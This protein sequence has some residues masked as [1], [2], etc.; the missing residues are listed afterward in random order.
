MSDRFASKLPSQRQLRVGEELRD[1]ISMALRR[2]DFRDPVLMDVNL[3]VTEVSVSPDLKNCTAYVIPLGGGFDA[4]MIKALNKA[5]SYLRSSVAREITT[6]HT[7]RINFAYDKSF[8]TGQKIDDLLNSDAV[9]RDLV[10]PETDT[11][12]T[13]TPQTETL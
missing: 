3:T 8:D 11:P 13:E 10:K 2:A 5:S 6:R 12:Q 1:L 4:T 9:R 7:P